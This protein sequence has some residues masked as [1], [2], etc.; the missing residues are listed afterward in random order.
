M[1]RHERLVEDGVFDEF[2][3]STSEM[4]VESVLRMVC[5]DTFDTQEQESR[6]TKGRGKK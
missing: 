3:G 5:V 6:A 2:G 4:G 1:T